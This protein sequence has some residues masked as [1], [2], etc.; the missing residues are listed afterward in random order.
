MNMPGFTAEASLRPTIG[1]YQGNTVFGGSGAAQILP[2]Q[3]LTIAPNLVWPRPW[4]KLVP[5]CF[6]DYSGKPR[7]SYHPVPL[8]YWCE[9]LPTELTCF[10]CYPPGSFAI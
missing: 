1:K 5:C 6:Y 2:M 9:R 8:W 7:C 3:E 10:V 4:E